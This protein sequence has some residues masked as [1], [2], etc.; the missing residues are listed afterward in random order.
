MNTF[1]LSC[2]LSIALSLVLTACD[3]AGAP[4]PVLERVR[5]FP[6]R[7]LTGVGV[8]SNGRIFVNFP[9]WSDD[10]DLSVAEILP[11]G[12]LE[13][14]PDKT[15]NRW[16]DDARRRPGEHFVCV[17]SVITDER[18][19]VWVLDP[20]NPQFRGV[21]PGGPKLVHI[22]PSTGEVVRVYRFDAEIAPEKSYLNDVRIDL[23]ARRAYITDSG[24]GAL[25]VV[26]LESGESRRLLEEHPAMHAEE[27][28]VPTI[29]GVALRDREGNVPQIHADGVAIDRA[30]NRV[31]VHALTA[32]RLYSLPTS[33]L[34]DFATS[35]DA[36][37]AAVRD[38]GPTDITDGMLC[39]AKGRGY[40][41]ALEHDAI[42]VWH[43]DVGRMETIVSD[44]RLAWPDSLDWGGDGSLYVTTS[45]IHRTPRFAGPDARTQPFA[46]WRIRWVD[47][48][49]R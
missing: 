24:L 34:D 39:D 40:H 41:T 43:G 10:V 12:Y 29:G 26:N 1:R 19:H 17:Q 13:P 2:F 15:W 3:R 48:E 45:L 9:R 28:V 6:D 32:K 23:P 7:Q 42:T 30:M 27:G 33:V 49:G 44:P 18:D 38:H 47:A 22:D 25:V 8:M 16:D 21:V 36:V 46:L 14:F 4:R 11:G 5:A 37:A 31:Y 35:R 20:A